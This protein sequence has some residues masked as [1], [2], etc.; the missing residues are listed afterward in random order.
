MR[1]GGW[2]AT[3]H[4]RTLSEKFDTQTSSSSLVSG[5]GGSSSWARL[6]SNLAYSG[7]VGDGNVN[8][9]GE[10]VGCPPRCVGAPRLAAREACEASEVAHREGSEH[11]SAWELGGATWGG[12]L[13]WTFTCPARLLTGCGGG[14]ETGVGEGRGV[15]EGEG[16]VRPRPSP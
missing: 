10:R 6:F 16:K 12:M 11:H 5:M 8:G 1:A 3:K 7:D 13:G 15:M 14:G 9:F 2:T 4:S